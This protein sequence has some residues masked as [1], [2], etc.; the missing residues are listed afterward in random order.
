M[1]GAVGAD[2]EKSI[3]G[4]SGGRRPGTQT[5]TNDQENWVGGL[6]RVGIVSTNSPL[7]RVDTRPTT[8]PVAGRYI[9]EPPWPRIALNAMTKISYACT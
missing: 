7:A 9:E 6:D 3:V 1:P 4:D 2:T 8:T 5:G